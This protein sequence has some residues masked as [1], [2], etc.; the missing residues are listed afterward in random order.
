MPRTR[1]VFG[2][3][4]ACLGHP[5]VVDMPAM[6]ASVRTSL[7]DLPS[8]PNVFVVSNHPRRPSPSSVRG[9]T[10]LSGHLPPADHTPPFRSAGEQP[11]SPGRRQPSGTTNHKRACLPVNHKGAAGLQCHHRRGFWSGSACPNTATTV[12]DHPPPDQF[13][14]P[15]SRS[16]IDVSQTTVDNGNQCRRACRKDVPVSEPDSRVGAGPDVQLFPTRAE[17]RGLPAA[18]AAPEH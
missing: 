1:T 14:G 18:R 5:P 9:R 3:L 6:V 15:G 17:A 8:V 4:G 2:Y 12:T 11:G 16:P 13:S 7:S 10:Y